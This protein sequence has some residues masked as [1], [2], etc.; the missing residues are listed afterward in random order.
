MHSNQTLEKLAILTLLI[1]TYLGAY[2]LN[3]VISTVY[4]CLVPKPLM[5][6]VSFSRF[7][8][9]FCN[10]DMSLCQLPM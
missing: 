6:L 3:P 1:F 9:F 7:R 2:L 4:N 8:L 10:L 5:A